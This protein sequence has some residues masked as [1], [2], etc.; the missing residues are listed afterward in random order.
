[1]NDEIIKFLTNLLKENYEKS[2]Y[3]PVYPASVREETLV[4]MRDN[5]KLRTIIHR[6]A[7]DNGVAEGRPLP[8]I[9]QRSCYESDL[10]YQHIH[11]DNLARRGYIYIIQFCRGTCGSEGKWEPNVNERN[12]GFDTITWLNRQDW[13]ESIGFWGNSYMALTGWA[14]ADIVPNKMKGM[15]L[16]HYGTDRFVSAYEKGMFRQDVLTSWAKDNAGFPITADYI[17]SYKFLPQVEVDEKLWGGRLEWYRDYITNTHLDDPFW[18]QGWWKELR[19]IPSRVK[20]PL[21]IRSGWYDHHHGSSMRTWDNLPE[22][23]KEHCWLD[24]GAWNHGFWPCTQDSSIENL[25]GN[26]E[27]AFLEW[28]DLILKKKQVPAKRIR[29]YVTA[30]DRWEEQDQWPSDSGKLLMLNFNS[31]AK[32]GYQGELI[33]V[34]EEEKGELHYI[35]NPE[36]PVTS[37]GVES[38]LRDMMNNGSLLQPEQGYREDVLSFVSEPMSESVSINGK[39]K[40]KL[41]VS[42]DCPDTAFTAKVMV[43]RENAQAYSI[44]SSITS[45]CHD[46]GCAY[47]PGNI[48]EV[49][50]EMWDIVYEI[51]KGSRIR[52]DLS[53]SDFPQYHIHRNYAGVWALQDKVQKANQTIYTG[54]EYPSRII[55]PIK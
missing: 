53:S 46:I 26:E 33:T 37:H 12:D 11:G 5:V 17:E 36:N 27:H 19:E 54:R 35:Y 24:I 28:F 29:T 43:V 6:P 3:D 45:L 1:M 14:V 52:V 7:D 31:Q 39:I 9:L 18:Q 48:E 25:Q 34:T 15:C 16:T 50:I 55:I 44:R 47:V 41:Y 13:A 49:T 2:G 21:Y 30:A 10:S 40:V 23:T 20:V 32:D 4:V 22:E 8:V 51:R 38:L 42:S